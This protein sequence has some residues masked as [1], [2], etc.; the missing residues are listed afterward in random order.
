MAKYLMLKHYRSGRPPVN[1]VPMD[2]LAPQEW[3]AHV[4]YMQDMEER[5]ISSG[6]LVSSEGLSMGGAWVRFDGEGRPP[7]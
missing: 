5:L 1:A 7:T 2:Q 4:Q 6:E 3:A